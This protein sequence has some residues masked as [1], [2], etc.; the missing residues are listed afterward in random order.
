MIDALEFGKAMGAIVRDALAPLQKQIDDLKTA[1]AAHQT[2]KGDPGPTGEPGR[3]AEPIEIADIVAELLVSSELK[4]LL[5]MQ[6]TES[7]SEYFVA[8]PVQHGRDGKDG[9]NGQ[10]GIAGAK[11]DTGD[12]GEGLACFIINR[13]GEL[14]ASTTKGN[15][16]VLGSVVGKDGQPGKDGNDGLSAENFER[17]Y[18]PASHEIRERWAVG[19]HAKELIY[20]AGGIR[21]I[22]YWR[23]GTEAKGG[24]ATTHDGTLWVALRDTKAKPSRESGDWNIGARKGR[25]GLQ[26]PAG[27]EYK[28]PEP[29]KL[30]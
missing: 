13:D 9:E 2:E 21:Y 8:N 10:Q 29:V 20:P 18:L 24:D 15:H 28:P 25:D 26:G 19:D 4:T 17:E 11:G 16:V 12:D 22:G 1:L 5:D 14:V 7:V 27:K 23:E 6:A 3:D 30:S